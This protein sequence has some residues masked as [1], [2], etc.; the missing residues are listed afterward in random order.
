MLIAILL[1]CSQAPADTAGA[2]DTGPPPADSTA[3]CEGTQVVTYNNFGH[4][5]LL[6]FCQGC[7]ASS[8]PTRYGAPDAVFFDTAEDAWAWSERILARAETEA[9]GM[10]PAGGISD[11]DRL[12]LS[13]WLRCAAPGT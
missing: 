4:G 3:P 2:V 5:F 6:T 7:H 12:L 10:P 9:G 8:T 13:H 11:E 1:S